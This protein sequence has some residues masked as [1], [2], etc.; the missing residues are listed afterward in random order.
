MI[1]APYP[2]RTASCDHKHRN[3]FSRSQKRRKST[4]SFQSV[5]CL[6]ANFCKQLQLF[7]LYLN[8]TPKP[9]RSKSEG[10]HGRWPLVLVKKQPA[11]CS[12]LSWL[13]Y[14]VCLHTKGARVDLLVPPCPSPNLPKNPLPRLGDPL[15]EIQYV[16]LGVLQ[17]GGKCP[18]QYRSGK[19]LTLLVKTS[20]GKML[21]NIKK[22]FSLSQYVV[23]TNRKIIEAGVGG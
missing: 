19:T 18:K 11:L 7:T 22:L 15:E 12:T 1:T 9:L 21:Q 23:P 4:A 17:E 13:L 14:G 20:P 2:K 5:P 8:R 3:L 10:Y 16:Q 6:P